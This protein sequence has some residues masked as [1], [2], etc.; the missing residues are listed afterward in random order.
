MRKLGA[1]QAAHATAAATPNPITGNH[2]ELVAELA[3]RHRLPLIG[4]FRYLI[5]SGCLVLKQT[6]PC[7]EI[8]FRGRDWA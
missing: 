2:R 1:S 7:A 3:M 4:A 8:R 5:T 6:R